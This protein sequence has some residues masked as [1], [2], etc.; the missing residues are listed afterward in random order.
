MYM[1]LVGQILSLDI[2]GACMILKYISMYKITVFYLVAKR[3]YFLKSTSIITIFLICLIVYVRIANQLLR[4]TRNGCQ[5]CNRTLSCMLC[6]YKSFTEL[7][8][9]VAS[10]IMNLQTLNPRIRIRYRN[11]RLHPSHIKKIKHK[12][13]HHLLLDG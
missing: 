10:F 13:K 12:N 4:P 8:G 9:D 6:I 2:K 5:G 3:F 11:P 7:I 1:A